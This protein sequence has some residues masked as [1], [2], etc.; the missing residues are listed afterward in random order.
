[1]LKRTQVRSRLKGQ[2]GHTVLHLPVDSILFNP[3]QPRK[4]EMDKDIDELAAS[5]SQ[6]GV[7]QPVVVRRMGRGYE[8]IAG[9]RRLR[10][11]KK[12]GIKTIP[13]LVRSVSDEELALLA[14]VE[15]LQRRGLNVLDEAEGYRNLIE[16]FGLTQE[17]VAVQVGKSQPTIANKLRL[18]KLPQGVL[19]E[20]RRGAFTERH[21]RALLRLPSEEQQIEVMETVLE[22]QLNVAQTDELVD[23]VTQ[24]A[25]PKPQVKRQRVRVFKDLRIF[26]NSFRQ[27][28][29]ALKRTGVEAVME[30]EEDGEFWRIRVSIAK[31]QEKGQEQ[32]ST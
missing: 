2:S 5:I 21:A 16:K 26:L 7:L 18:F 1:M 19:E 24:E 6:H 4:T 13:A 3:Y 25:S 30:E 11:C 27:V 20:L 9:E 14:L 31:P 15:N 17:E 32:V 29:I 12:A 22:G 10:A 8:L 23:E 28:V